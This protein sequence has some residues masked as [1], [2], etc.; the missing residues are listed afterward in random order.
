MISTRQ[1]I[2]NHLRTPFQGIGMQPKRQIWMTL[3]VVAFLCGAGLFVWLSLR[4][5]TPPT[6]RLE[7][8]VEPLGQF[9]PQP[10]TQGVRTAF[11]VDLNGDG[12]TEAVAV[13]TK[14]SFERGELGAWTN[15]KNEFRLLPAL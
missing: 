2:P 7:V 6:P 14:I 8:T 13:Y 9:P 3:G 15:L 11:P 5:P 4:R 12:E 10:A 1:E